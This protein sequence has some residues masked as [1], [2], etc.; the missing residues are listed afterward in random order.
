MIV[1]LLGLEAARRRGKARWAVLG[2]LTGILLSGIWFAAV[3]PASRN[4]P[5]AQAAAA[6]T[7]MARV[8]FNMWRSAPV[9]GVGNGRFYEESSGFGATALRSLNLGND[10]ENAHDNF[11]QVLAEEGLVG[12]G[13]LAIVLGV[14]LVPALRAERSASDPLRR[15]A[16]AGVGAYLLTWLSGH[17][18]LQPEA[19]L[20]FWLLTGTLAALTGACAPARWRNGLVVV[21]VVLS[22]TAPIRADWI[23]RRASFE[24]IGVGVSLWQPALD[25]LRYR[26]AG[27]AFSL[28]LP[29]DGSF[30]TLPMRRAPGAADPLLLSVSVRGR[31]AAEERIEGD[32]W[33]LVQL[34]LPREHR[35][36]EL[37]DFLV[38][39]PANGPGTAPVV[40]VGKAIPH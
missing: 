24:H 23:I 10:H 8:S 13:A 9:F 2:A 22:V 3:Y 28:Y 37:V 4:A 6:R 30:V 20:S 15:F 33:R 26:E 38:E 31:M 1:V 40:F 12:L 39:G 19:A 32:G 35:R 25:G 16:L 5:F 7:I 36:F 14:V 29:A 21:A 17:P 27:R 34:R 18:Q 11:L